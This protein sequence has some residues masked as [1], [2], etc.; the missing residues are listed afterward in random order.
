MHGRLLPSVEEQRFDRQLVLRDLLVADLADSTLA[1]P[2]RDARG[3]VLREAAVSELAS[4][5]EEKDL[6]VHDAQGLSG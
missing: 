1:R 6:G 5:E 4:D 2:A 3:P